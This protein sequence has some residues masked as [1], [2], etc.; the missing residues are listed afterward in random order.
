MKLTI[1]GSSSALPTSERNPSAHVL[2]AHERLYLID[3]GEG[4]QMQ[5]RKCKI[6][7]S[8][9]NHIFISHLHGDHIFGLFGLLSSFNLMGR[10][11]PLNIYAP[12]NFNKILKS[13]LEDFDI[14]LGFEVIFTEL[15]CKDP[16]VILDDKYLT[17]TAFPLR[18]RIPAF[19]FL[20][21]EKK[22]D[23]KIRKEKIEVYNI[24][25]AKMN[26]IKKGED[27]IREDG[28]IIKN[29]EITISPP[30]P[31]SYAYCSDT[32]YFQQLSSYVKGTDLIYHEATFGND[33]RD[34]AELTGHSTAADAARVASEAGAG[35]L[36]IGH[37]SSRYKNPEILVEQA[38]EI[39]PSTYPAED[40]KTYKI[41][42]N[43]K[44]I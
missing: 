9:I 35:T 2:C 38:R 1:L 10:G 4:T 17:V 31:L 6:R 26:A 39:F 29:E 32:S 3:C 33:L 5:M 36:I 41:I 44:N 42:D 34:L 22:A 16:F 7:F 14:K 30:K 11:Q 20:F 21:S 25:I 13:Y 18:H 8:K 43:N 24:P 12:A 37:F 40:G 19:G 23:R 28:I 27:L 15:N